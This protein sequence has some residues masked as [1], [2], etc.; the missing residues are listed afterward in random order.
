MTKATMT[1][2]SGASFHIGHATAKHL[3]AHHDKTNINFRNEL[4]K[5]INELRRLKHPSSA[6][7]IKALESIRR[8]WQSSGYRIG[9]VFHGQVQ[10]I[11]SHPASIG[12]LLGQTYGFCLLRGKHVEA[13]ALAALVDQAKSHA[14][15][16]ATTNQLTLNANGVEAL[17]NPKSNAFIVVAQRPRAQRPG[18]IYNL[19]RSISALHNQT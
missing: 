1:L 10:K 5:A 4:A 2:V 12:F 17:Y 13:T 3:V 9:N 16:L 8:S 11:S 7:A 14:R 19:H 15:H 18:A 6:A